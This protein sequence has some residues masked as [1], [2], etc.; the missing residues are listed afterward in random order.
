MTVTFRW[1]FPLFVSHTCRSRIP[2]K[3][4]RP[5]DS[6]FFFECWHFVYPFWYWMNHVNYYRYYYYRYY[7]MTEFQILI[8]ASLDCIR[9]SIQSEIIR[10]IVKRRRDFFIL[11]KDLLMAAFGNHLRVYERYSI[12]VQLWVNKDRMMLV[13]TWVTFLNVA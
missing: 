3:C 12:F 10:S 6:R 5:L 4:C 11:I 1:E 7:I 9:K 2:L 13:C 8:E